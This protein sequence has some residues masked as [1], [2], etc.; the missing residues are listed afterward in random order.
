MYVVYSRK[1]ANA[2]KLFS[3]KINLFPAMMRETLSESLFR[4][5]FI[6]L[7]E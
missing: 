1:V 7:L 3:F 5:V 4:Y 2:S 6:F